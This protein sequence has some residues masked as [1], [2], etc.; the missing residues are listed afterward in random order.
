M[1]KR[2]QNELMVLMALI[3][4]AF[5]MSYKL[6]SYNDLKMQTLES[7]KFISIMDDIVTMKKLWKKNKTIPN[8]LEEIKSTLAE[9]KINKFEIDKKKAHIILQ[10]LNG[11]ELNNILGKK[12]ASIPL[13]IKELIITRDGDNYRLELKCKW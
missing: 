7:A 1:L 6:S 8:K 4:L 13:Q 9:S 11:T 2:Y 3:V 12:I 10:T 5:S